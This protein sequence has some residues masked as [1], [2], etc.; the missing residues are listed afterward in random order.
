MGLLQPPGQPQRFGLLSPD[1]L[2]MLNRVATAPAPMPA[3]APQ[4]NRVSG[5]R[6]FDRV[7]GGQTVSEGLDAERERLRAEALRPQMEAR[8][9]AIRDFAAR[10]GPV[11]MAALATNPGK[12]G[13]AMASNLEGYTLGAGG[14]RGGIGGQVASAPTF[15]T[16]N[17]TIYRNDPGAG[18]STATA[19]APAAF[20]DQTARFNAENP[21]LAANSTWVGPDGRPRAQ[22][23]IA[24]EIANVA[25]GGEALVFDA[26]GNV[27]NRVASS[28]VKPMS[29]ADQTAVAAAERTLTQNRTARNRAA[30][31]REQLA[32]GD[33]NL[34]PLTNFIGGARNAMGR[35]TPNSL[36]QDAL[37][38]WA[39]EA[40]DA[41]LSAATGVQTDGDAVRALER[42]IS[43]PND[44]RVVAAALARFEESQ[45]ATAQ[46]F[47]RDIARRSGAQG[48]ASASRSGPIAQDA[49]GNRVQWN[50]SAWVP[51]S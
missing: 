1:A 13:E 7:L 38:S 6:V 22:G 35:S 12:F 24:P 25:P 32:S 4:R 44:E 9:A 36:N 40:R 8:E 10:Q 21:V 34:G 48:G 50:G 20:S 2:G 51:I 28:Q 39:K 16:V 23:Y 3:A 49:R 5:W 19:T 18:T 15:S 27:T 17:D 37:M 33:L 14:V 45:A 26:Q 47:E 31:F 41:I 29:D 30:Q 43:T 42:I 46:V 11:A